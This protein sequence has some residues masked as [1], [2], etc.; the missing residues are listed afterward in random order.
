M[1]LMPF[2]YTFLDTRAS[3]ITT[4]YVTSS[5][6]GKNSIITNRKSTTRFSN[7]PKMDMYFV[8]K[9]PK[10][11]QKCKTAVYPLKSNFA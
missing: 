4:T 3:N 10:G 6:N 8:P 1:T 9:P 11:T 7:E 5:E 2:W